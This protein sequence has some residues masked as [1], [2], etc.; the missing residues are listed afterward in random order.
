M[1]TQKSPPE[2]PPQN[3]PSRAATPPPA[4][5]LKTASGT[6]APVQTPVSNSN[7][8]QAPQTVAPKI[9]T[10]VKLPPPAG[11]NIPVKVSFFFCRKISINRASAT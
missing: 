1:E 11:N 7:H 6:P 10:P 3:P 8:Q 4:K 2:S 5:R 9:V